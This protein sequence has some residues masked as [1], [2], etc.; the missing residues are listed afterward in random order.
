M[1][2][3]DL[4]AQQ[5]RI[6]D[7]IDQNIQNVLAHGKYIMGPEVNELEQKLADYA[8]TKYAVGVASGT[9]ALLMPLMAYET[10]PGDAIF[11]VSFTFI[12]TAEVVQLLGATPVFVDIDRET[13]N[14]DYEKLEEAI[15]KVKN[16]GKLTPKG[17]IPV[18]L[19]GQPADYDEINAIAKKYGL[20]VLEDAAQGFGGVYKGRRAG[21]LADVAGT[22]FF[23][24]KPLGTYGDG[25]MVFTDDAGMLDK[26]LSI[27]VHGQGSDKYNNIR[28]GINGRLDT[29]MAAI[30][31]PKADIFEEEIG[32]RQNV[33]NRYNE[34]LETMVKTPYVKDHN[35]S[36]WAQ[37]SILHPNREQ[38][39]AGLKEEGIPTAVYYPKPLHLQDAFSDLGYKY[40]DMPVSE[41]VAGEIFSIPMHPYLEE[42]DQVK[43]ADAIKKYA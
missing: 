21:S 2:F 27:R 39:M 15:I 14:M 17:I 5:D 33:A 32:L 40:G 18:D 31:L 13:Y 25:G 6:K 38:V 3:I 20:W 24:A 16:E 9:D 4:K 19:F 10:G 29:L 41:A 23:P 34:L 1:Q 42:S 28:I 12:A 22:S 11:T 8:G 35:T 36:A 26:L 30:L 7:K 37:Y 43:I